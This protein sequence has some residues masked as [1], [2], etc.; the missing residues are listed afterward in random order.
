M[1]G[2]QPPAAHVQAMPTAASSTDDH[3][4]Q[5]GFVLSTMPEDEVNTS[6]FSI[7][8]QAVLPIR[9]RDQAEHE[10]GV[11]LAARPGIRG[12]VVIRFGSR[13]AWHCGGLSLSELHASWRH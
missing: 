11:R 5:W 4:V 10:L 2:E 3:T 8:S 7:M 1:C 12:G 6:Y 9:Y 13:D